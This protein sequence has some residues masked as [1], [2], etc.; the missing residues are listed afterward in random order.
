[1]SM[2]DCTAR[3]GVMGGLVRIAGAFDQGERRR[4]AGL[5]AAVT[6]LHLLGWGLIAL[7]APAH[8]VLAGLGVLAYSFGLR[9]AF[10]AD[11][12]S[13]IDNTTRRLLA[14]GGR[15]LTVGFFFSLGHSTVVFALSIG[16]AVAVGTVHSVLPALQLYGG[17]VGAVVSGVLLWTIG[18]LNLVVLL[19]IW[20]LRRQ[21][22][23]GGLDEPALESR[24]LERG[25]M[26]R[27][28][29]R[30]MALVRSSR[31]MYPLGILFGLGFD[32]ATE[33]G[34]LALTAGVA[35]GRVPLAATLALPVLFAAGM[36]LMDTADGVF[37]S[38]A[39]SWAFGNA[40]RKL[41]YNLTVT[42]L[43]VAVALLIGT[44]ELAQVTAG[45]LRL[46]GSFWN[47]LE[48][49]NFGTLGYAI[50]GMFAATWLIAFFIWRW[51]GIGNR[52]EL[53]PGGAPPMDA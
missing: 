6:G 45:R 43:S 30:P 11:H 25:F 41:F 3:R 35:S 51:R 29:R 19:G 44:I 37:M 52:W 49:L 1:M 50:V 28:L 15:P 33:V 36:S 53:P 10:D 47:W 31:Q 23:G 20:D 39:Y 9:H 16:L 48:R 12:I 13:A 24:L 42:G 22:A 18:L 26:C 2:G 21:M 5:G 7:Y 38:K 8:P 4:L 34:L 46:T 27:F 14:D 32:T 40:A 17:T